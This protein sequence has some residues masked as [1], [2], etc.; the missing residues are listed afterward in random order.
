[1]KYLYDLQK[2]SKDDK[3]LCRLLTIHNS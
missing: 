2:S 1:M 3:G